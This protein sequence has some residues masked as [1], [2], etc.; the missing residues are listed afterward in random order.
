MTE[1]EIR[2]FEQ[3]NLERRLNVIPDEVTAW[4]DTAK[5]G[6]NFGI[7]SSQMD[8]LE[9]MFGELAADQHQQL[10][11]V[12]QAAAGTPF[13]DAFYSLLQKLN[14][15][16]DL[17]R[18]FYSVLV[19]RRDDRWRCLMD[20][21]D[22]IASDCYSTGIQKAE[23]WNVR[24][25]DEVRAP[26]LTYLESSISPSTASRGESV[27]NLGFPVRQYR[28]LM[29]PIPIVLF[30]FDQ[31]D[32]LWMLC[33]LAHEVGHNLDHDLGPSQGRR[34]TDV[35]RMKLIGLVPD[36]REVQWRRWLQEI[37]ADVIGVLLMGSGF[38]VSM[39][40]LTTP[41]GP[42]TSF[43]EPDEDAV[44]PPFHLRLR[45]L[46]EIAKATQV[47]SVAG[48]GD[49]LLQLVTN[50]AHPVWQAPYEDDADSIAKMFVNDKLDSLKGH[51]LLELGGNLA[52]ADRQA[53]KLSAHWI[54]SNQSR[55]VPDGQFPFPF[56]LVPAAAA[57]A[58]RELQNP[59]KEMIRKLQSTAREYFDA[60]PRPNF[61]PGPGIQA[62][63]RAYRRSLASR[64]KFTP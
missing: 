7:H 24:A 49:E 57:L 25:R 40:Y 11:K 17:W 9:D 48:T 34:L 54:D 62:D 5:K 58:V 52:F 59:D 41:L 16:E 15:A 32:S 38:A 42:A 31:V 12:V 36:V 64:L 61:L 45:L 4:T 13:A 33:A 30:P 21:A 37:F 6:G 2:S 46:G 14:G 50:A 35:F 51:S 56:R 23:D 39:A 22:L 28:N 26:P 3:A 8:A 60:I 44:H 1:A 47:A 19:Q 27:N 63:Q 55:P 43:Q 53:M 29:L 10:E 20:M 18:I